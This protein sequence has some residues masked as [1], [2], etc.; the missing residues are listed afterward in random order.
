MTYHYFRKRT[1]LFACQDRVLSKCPRA[2]D[3]QALSG[4]D[5]K[6]M[7]KGIDVLCKDVNGKPAFVRYLK[8]TLICKHRGKKKAY[9]L[10]GVNI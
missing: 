9:F 10:H 7:Q 3:L 4:N 1:N 5:Q 6:S 8:Q 2:R